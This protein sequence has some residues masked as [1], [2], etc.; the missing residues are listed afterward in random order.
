MYGAYG[1]QTKIHVNIAK[2][3]AVASEYGV[4]SAHRESHVRLMYSCKNE[5]HQ[6]E[7]PCAHRQ[8]RVRKLN[9]YLRIGRLKD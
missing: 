8:Y 7:I 9:E 4:Y 5:Q 2:Y 1:A 3:S 6:C